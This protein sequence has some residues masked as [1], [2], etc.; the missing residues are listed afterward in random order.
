MEI[1]DLISK[2]NSIKDPKTGKS[3]QFITKSKHQ[4]LWNFYKGQRGEKFCYTPHADTEGNY[5]C[6][7]YQ[8]IGKGSRT[9]KPKQWK[10]IK[11][12]RCAK[13]KVAQQKAYKR[14]LTSKEYHATNS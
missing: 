10:C 1:L 11:L 2:I 9:G 3:I 5:W 8:P 12:V 14:F 7:T 13:R 6:F 4:H